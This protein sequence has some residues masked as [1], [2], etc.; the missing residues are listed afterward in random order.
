MPLEQRFRLKD[1]DHL[2]QELA[3]GAAFLGQ[4]ET[5]CRLSFISM[6]HCYERNR[7]GAMPWKASENAMGIACFRRCYEL[8]LSPA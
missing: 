6:L 4:G 5:D 2:G 1:G 3:H 8:C 7:L